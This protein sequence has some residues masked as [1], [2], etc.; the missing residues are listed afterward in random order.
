MQ[1]LK[2]FSLASEND[3]V[4]FVMSSASYKLDMACY[5]QN[6]AY[7]FHIFPKMSLSRLDFEP[8]TIFY[9]GN[10][11]G[12][13]TLLNVIAKK[14]N[15]HRTAPFND[16]PHFAEY[17]EFCTYS[18]CNG[19]KRLPAGSEIVTSDGVFDLLLD[20][21]AINSGIDRER[22]E[23]FEEYA[24]TVRDCRENGWQMRDLSQYDELC[25]RMDAR[26]KTKSQYVTSR[27]SSTAELPT[28]SNGESAFLYFTKRIKENA[29]YLLDE[30]ENSLSPKL[31]LELAEFLEASVRFYGCQLIVSTHS[32]FLLAM[33]G[34]KIYDLDS[35]PAS[36]RRWS[37]LENVKAYFD[38]F[39]THEKEF[40]QSK[41]EN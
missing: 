21:R 34:A 39:K 7:P 16:S 30:P 4:D 9:G 5:S 8:I 36:I 15:I 28:R 1:Y 25:R 19:Q 6:N 22:E 20:V 18:L 12:K 37:E 13:S 11:S 23:L 32:P 40:N 29:L 31:Q 14:L 3:E 41:K 10:G 17:L 33:K 35:R 38:L 24:E 26:K 27:M 2:S